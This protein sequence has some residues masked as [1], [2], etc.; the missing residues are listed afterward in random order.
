M[1]LNSRDELPIHYQAAI[2]APARRC[3]E[4]FNYVNGLACR[5]LRR[6][7]APLP[8]EL[9][10][11]ALLSIK[12]LP[13]HFMS[14][15]VHCVVDSL[16]RACVVRYVVTSN[17]S[18]RPISDPLLGRPESRAGQNSTIDTHAHVYLCILDTSITILSFYIFNIVYLFA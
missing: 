4:L 11:A 3:R 15:H 7:L 16:T 12:S 8:R 2:D 6:R 9:A 5:P 17:N 13:G 10:A 14:A 18:L 1:E